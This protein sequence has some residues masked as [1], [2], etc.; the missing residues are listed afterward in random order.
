[1]VAGCAVCY[2][3]GTLWYSALSGTPLIASV[4]ACVVPFLPC[5]VVKILRAALLTCRLRPALQRQG[6]L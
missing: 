3:F 1:M 2:F 4:S 6:L 5:D